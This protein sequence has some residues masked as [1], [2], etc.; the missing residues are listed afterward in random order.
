MCAMILQH[1]WRSFM[2][3]FVYCDFMVARGGVLV[4]VARAE[5]SNQPITWP[6]SDPSI[7]G[8]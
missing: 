1:S 5:L 2:R 6:F 8:F 3:P 7:R 4:V